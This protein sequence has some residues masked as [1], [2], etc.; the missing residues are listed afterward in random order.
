MMPGGQSGGFHPAKNNEKLSEN[1]FI[2]FCNKVVSF[3]VRFLRLK[4]NFHKED[5]SADSTLKIQPPKMEQEN[6]GYF[7]PPSG[8]FCFWK[9]MLFEKKIKYSFSA[10]RQTKSSSKRIVL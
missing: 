7:Y 10:N 9:N 6:N 1:Q 5:S 3:L 2:I 8:S 4:N